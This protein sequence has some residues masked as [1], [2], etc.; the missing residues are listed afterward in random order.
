MKVI[1]LSGTEKI[2]FSSLTKPAENAEAD[3]VINMLENNISDTGFNPIDNINLDAF[4]SNITE[5]LSPEEKDKKRKLVMR[6]SKYY[7]HYPDCLG[8]CPNLKKMHIYQLEDLA[9]EVKLNVSN[10]N[11][12]DYLYGG[13]VVCSNLIEQMGPYIGLDLEG[14][15]KAVVTNPSI[16]SLT[17][18]CSL[19]RE[20]V[21]IPPEYRLIM[22]SLQIALGVHHANK[23]TKPK[24]D[25]EISKNLAEDY[26]DL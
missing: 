6:L 7:K 5:N 17:V 13:Y 12:D 22:T 25:I 23:I 16:K 20:I 9:E 3:D 19:E 15:T 8:E 18:E 2:D 10:W 21:Y 1:N 24:K 4:Q 26:K 14:Y 11:T